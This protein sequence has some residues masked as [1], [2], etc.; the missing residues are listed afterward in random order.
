VPLERFTSQLKKNEKRI[1]GCELT[2]LHGRAD[3]QNW[4]VKALRR[5]VTQG[6]IS[7]S[8]YIEL[9]PHGPHLH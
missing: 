9:H 2:S 4:Q 5:R 7:H 1:F 8:T 6:T 3:C